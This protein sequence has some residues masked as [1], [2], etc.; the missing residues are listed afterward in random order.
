LISGLIVAELLHHR[1][2]ERHHWMPLLPGIELARQALNAIHG[3][4]GSA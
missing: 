3:S 4:A 2:G 1:D